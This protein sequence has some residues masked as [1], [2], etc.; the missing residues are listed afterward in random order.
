MKTVKLTHDYTYVP[1]EGSIHPVEGWGYA[2]CGPVSIASTAA[3]DLLQ[4]MQA[5]RK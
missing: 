5:N 2:L 4:E 1:T 3:R